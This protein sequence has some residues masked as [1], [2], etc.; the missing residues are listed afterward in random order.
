MNHELTKRLSWLDALRGFTMIL[1]VAYHVA[2]FSFQET[3][4]TSAA[5]P[6]LV[7]MRMPLFFFV[8]GF[9]AYKASFSWTIPNA[10]KLTW[11]KLKVQIIPTLVFMCLFVIFRMKGN[12]SD[13]FMRLLASPTKGGYWFTWVL[14]QMFIIYYVCCYV[15]QILSPSPSKGEDNKVSLLRGDFEGSGGLV[16]AGLLFIAWAASVFA[17]ETLYLPKVFTYHKD[18]FFAYSSLVQTIRYMQFFL[19]GNIVRRYWNRVEQL[20]DSPWFFPLVVTLA[21]VCCAEIFQLHTLKRVWVNLP[22]T[23]AMYALLLLVVMFFR[24]YQ[25]WFEEG[26]R[27]GRFLSFIGTRTLDIYLL[28]FLLLPKIPQVGQWLNANQPNFLLSIVLSV[29]V[30]LVVIAFCLLASQLLRVSP[31]LQLYLFGK[32]PSASR[33]GERTSAKPTFGKMGGGLPLILL[34]AFLCFGTLSTSAKK[35]EKRH[36]V[37]IET[38][39]GNIRVALSDDTPLHSKN[40]L[41]LAREG[42]YDGT[43]FHRCIKNFMIQGG[44][45]DSRGAEPG[46]LLGEGNVGY[47]IP[48]E[49]CLPYWYHWRGALAAAREPDDVNPEKESSGCQFYIVYGKKQAAADIRK[50]RTMLEEK[51]IELTPQMIDDYY[52]RGGTPHLDGQ[53]TVFG[54]VI[55]GMEVVKSI[56]QA[57]TDENDR[58]LKDIVI[59]RMVVEQ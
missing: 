51:G 58:P 56:Q 20:F 2:Q 25:A 16:G 19:L 49:F 11:K 17:Y 36:V 40:F 46:K 21:V 18:P 43:L 31:F 1:V 50:V 52:M 26:Q 41:K 7:L 59:L 30:A 35:K 10:L 34:L 48:A 12:F 27:V 37:R 8:S 14:L 47:T 6:F 22:R 24:H 39:M 28:H 23:T 42:F 5:L 53:Y 4:K 29:S 3:E 55:E 32:A 57:E 13:N 38:S 15:G 9:L 33:E 45:P 44:D 54:E